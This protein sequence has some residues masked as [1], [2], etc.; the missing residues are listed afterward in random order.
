ML[1]FNHRLTQHPRLVL[2][3]QDQVVRLVGKD[4]DQHT[5]VTHDAYAPPQPKRRRRPPSGKLS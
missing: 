1:G 4:P 2:S 5:K 3:Q